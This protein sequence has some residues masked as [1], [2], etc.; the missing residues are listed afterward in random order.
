MFRLRP[1]IHLIALIQSQRFHGL[2]IRRLVLRGF[3]LSDIGEMGEAER[4]KVI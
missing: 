2:V 1:P 3:G 4:T